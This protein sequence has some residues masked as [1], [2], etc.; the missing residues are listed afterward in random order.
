MAE[1]SVTS[2]QQHAADDGQVETSYAKDDLNKEDVKEVAEE[3]AEQEVEKHED[4]MHQNEA[5]DG[6]K[7]GQSAVEATLTKSFINKKAEEE[8]EA[9]KIRL[10]RA[11]NVAMEMQRKGML[12]PTRPALNRQVDNIMDFDDKAFEA[13]KRSVDNF[14]GTNTKTASDVAGLNVGLTDEPDQ[15]TRSNTKLDAES[16]SALWPEK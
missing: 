10:R 16:L 13:F 1:K 7:D 4:E 6:Q 2:V 5:Q 12:S 3:E 15:N 11:F 14:K 9:Y 8:R